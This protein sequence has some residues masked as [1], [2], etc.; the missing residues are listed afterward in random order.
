[1]PS[2]RLADIVKY[3]DRLLRI[4]EFN[5]WDGALNGLQVANGDVNAPGP[6]LIT[7]VIEV[8]SG[9]FVKPVP[10]LTFTCAVNVCV[11]P[12]RFVVRWPCRCRV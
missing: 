11:A 10:S 8:P 7:K 6:E 3:S 5:D 1:M 4:G 2:A 9:A 12:T